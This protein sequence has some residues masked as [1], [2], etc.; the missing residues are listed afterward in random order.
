MKDQM[1]MLAGKHRTMM[2]KKRMMMAAPSKGLPFAAL[3]GKKKRLLG[4]APKKRLL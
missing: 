4:A 2:G 1:M 3:S